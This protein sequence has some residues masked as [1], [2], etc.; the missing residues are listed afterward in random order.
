M[1]TKLIAS[2]IAIVLGDRL[3]TRARKLLKQKRKEESNSEK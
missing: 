1:H 2:K 3:A